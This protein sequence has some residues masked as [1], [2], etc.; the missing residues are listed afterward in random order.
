MEKIKKAFASNMALIIIA[1]LA[2]VTLWYYS[3]STN[4]PLETIE[5]TVPLE[6]RN[7]EQLVSNGRFL[8]NS[9]ELEST[10]VILRISAPRNVHKDIRDDASN[11]LVSA[12]IDF[13]VSG[14]LSE[15]E[16]KASLDFKIPQRYD[17]PALN[18]DASIKEPRSTV[19]ALDILEEKTLK[20]EVYMDDPPD[21]FIYDVLTPEPN[22]ITIT[23]PNNELN[24]ITKIIVDIT[25][26]KGEIIEADSPETY[27]ATAAPQAVDSRGNVVENEN[28]DFGGVSSINVS[29]NILKTKI[30]L[31]TEPAIIGKPADGYAL[32]PFSKI[33]YTP[34]EI[35]IK[36]SKNQVENAE[37]IKLE[38]INIEGMTDKIEIITIQLRPEL[39]KFGN[40][41]DF[42][43]QRNDKVEVTINIEEIKE[44]TYQYPTARLIE[45]N[46]IVGFNPITMA[47]TTPSFDISIS[48]VKSYIDY[49]FSLYENIRATAD[50]TEF[51]DYSPGKYTVPVELERK[52]DG[53]SIISEQPTITIEILSE[54]IETDSPETE[55][56]LDNDN[57]PEEDNDI[58]IINPENT[59]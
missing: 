39:Q 49:S 15:G 26:P 35:E 50:V 59:N 13:S 10:T 11:G 54:I 51:A 31:I 55:E 6:L 16:I 24:K 33:T 21:D 38:P 25:P 57:E 29:Y 32:N 17:D 43:S 7:V 48:S 37:I 58:I 45:N 47:I 14:F 34:E 44:K 12:F 52:G 23:G 41:L 36:G 5:Y 40:S 53:Y 4:N 1:F 22:E 20:V 9:R 30:L 28:I 56:P 19:V 2:S 27:F 3:Y 42:V 46:D 18:V 8:I